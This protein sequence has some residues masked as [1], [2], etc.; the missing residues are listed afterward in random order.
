MM[1]GKWFHRIA[2][3]LIPVGLLTSVSLA[4]SVMNRPPVHTAA[5]PVD[6][7]AI[8]APTT[9]AATEEPVVTKTVEAQQTQTPP[10]APAPADSAQTGQPAPLPELAEEPLPELVVDKT[11][12]TQAMVELDRALEQAK[13][14]VTA[15]DPSAQGRY[16]QETV[17]VLA[18]FADPAFRAV[19]ATASTDAYKGVRPLLVEARVK[20]EAAEVQWIAAVQQQ[21]EARAKKLAEIAQA[22]GNVQIP[23][24][25]ADLSQTVG[26]SG[27]LGTRGVRVEEQAME[28]VSRAIRQATEALGMIPGR[29][30]GGSSETEEPS[31]AS[32]QAT[33]QME[34]VVRQLESA[35]KI[36]QIAI[37]R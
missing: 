26:P 33:S 14:A 20:R 22:G 6:E 35:K 2:L 30:S 13:L 7:E 5:A 8:T 19:T 12:L 1:K 34:Y 28:I 25:T 9:E 4:F 18:G 3:A 10:P 32:E 36:L 24:A 11:P 27:V 17:N 29:R 15:L 21:M 23:T 37:D 31:V 16:V